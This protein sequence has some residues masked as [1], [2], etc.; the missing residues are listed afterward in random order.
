MIMMHMS[1]LEDRIFNNIWMSSVKLV[2]FCLPNK[3]VEAKLIK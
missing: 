2:Y 3:E 1:K